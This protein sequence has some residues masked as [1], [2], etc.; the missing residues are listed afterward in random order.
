MDIVDPFPIDHRVKGLDVL[1][2]TILILQI[3][4]MFPNIDPQNGCLALADGTVLIR[5]GQYCQFALM[6]GQPGP[7]APGVR[8]TI[9]YPTS[10]RAVMGL[11]GSESDRGVWSMR[12][13]FQPAW[14]I[15]RETSM[16]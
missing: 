5:G 16:P 14:A 13:I 8:V 3:V 15:K 10:T 11:R 7:P 4:G 12:F 6:D 2:A 9:S 1:R